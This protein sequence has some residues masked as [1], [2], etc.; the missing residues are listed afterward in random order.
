MTSQI[1]EWVV[2]YRKGGGAFSNLEASLFFTGAVSV[3]DGSHLPTIQF[4]VQGQNYKFQSILVFPWNGAI[5]W[6]IEVFDMNGKNLTEISPETIPLS[7]SD[8]TDAA[9]YFAFYES[10]LL[11]LEIRNQSGALLCVRTEQIPAQYIDQYVSGYIGFCG[12][13]G[14]S[15]T[16]TSLSCSIKIE[17]F[18]SVHDM[19]AERYPYETPVQIVTTEEGANV[20][21]S[22]LA[23]VGNE[24]IASATVGN[25][26]TGQ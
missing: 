26:Q 15:L 1:A 5:D 4:N 16:F 24:V 18:D 13:T 11:D 14:E 3:A 10:G 6:L 20:V 25:W 7:L 17:T 23:I 19:T 21:Q 12:W 2:A 8:L 9:I 22:I